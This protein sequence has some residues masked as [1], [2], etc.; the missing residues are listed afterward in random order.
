MGRRADGCIA[1]CGAGSKLCWRLKAPPGWQERPCCK[2][3]GEFQEVEDGKEK[4]SRNTA[5]LEMRGWWTSAFCPMLTQLGVCRSSD[6]RGCSVR[7][8][9]WTAVT[10]GSWSRRSDLYISILDR[11]A[12]LAARSSVQIGRR[13]S[14][15]GQRSV[16]WQCRWREISTPS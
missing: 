2:L 14:S 11:R 8:A 13:N 4:R 1:Q 16:E 15:R 3:G 9:V 6:N 10:A 12:E 5:Q 7:K